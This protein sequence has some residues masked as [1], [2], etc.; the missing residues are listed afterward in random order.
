MALIYIEETDSKSITMDVAMRRVVQAY[1]VIIQLDT[2]PRTGQKK[3]V[4][5]AAPYLEDGEIKLHDIVTWHPES[6]D[7]YFIG[8]WQ[9]IPYL[10]G[11]WK[12]CYRKNH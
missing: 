7:E 1:D 8:S 2:M 12:K 11:W 9:P 5:I 6:E 10:N 3:I 4:H